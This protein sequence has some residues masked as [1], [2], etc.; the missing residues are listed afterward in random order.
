LTN[1]KENMNTLILQ[2]LMP[3][4]LFCVNLWAPNDQM[5]SSREKELATENL[6]KGLTL[7]T[8][9]F[10]HKSLKKWKAKNLELVDN[11][12]DGKDHIKLT[13]P[14][15]NYDELNEAANALSNAHGF[16]TFE[17]SPYMVVDLYSDAQ[18]EAF[19]SVV[20]NDIRTTLNYNGP[21]VVCSPRL[22]NEN[23][24]VSMDV[25]VNWAGY[26]PASDW[27]D[28]QRQ[29]IV[30]QTIAE[31][32]LNL[33]GRPYSII[34]R[35]TAGVKKF[36]SL[37]DMSL[38]AI[39]IDDIRYVHGQTAYLLK[40]A[41][42]SIL[43]VL[44]ENQLNGQEV[45]PVTWSYEGNSDPTIFLDNHSETSEGVE[46]KAT[47]GNVEVDIKVVLVD[48]QL[49]EVHFGGEG[50]KGLNLIHEKGGLI[51][52]KG[53]DGRYYPKREP[54]GTPI[55][56]EEDEFGPEW[57]KEEDDEISTVAFSAAKSTEIIVKPFLVTTP[58]IKEDLKLLQIKAKINIY[59]QQ[60]EKEQMLLSYDEERGRHYLKESNVKFSVSN[61]IKLVDN[62]T[63]EWFMKEEGGS[64]GTD[65]WDPIATTSH[66]MYQTYK[67]SNYTGGQ[68]Y[69]YY[70]GCGKAEGL[71]INSE[72]AFIDLIWGEFA[73]LKLYKDEFDPAKTR[74]Q[75]PD[76]LR[77]H[78]GFGFLCD[79]ISI[80]SNDEENGIGECG[81]F[82][83]L[84][85]LIL[86]SHG[87]DNVGEHLITTVGREVDQFIVKDWNFIGENHDVLDPRFTHLNIP[88]IKY[89]GRIL[90]VIPQKLVGGNNR[91][92]WVYEEV[93]DQPGIPAQGYDPEDHDNPWSAFGNHK[94]VKIGNAYYDPSYGKIYSSID[95]LND[96][97]SFASQAVDGFFKERPRPIDEAVYNVDLNEDGDM[98][99]NIPWSV[100]LFIKREDSNIKFK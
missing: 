87:I 75:Y 98:N 83:R 32:N 76:P 51:L 43:P 30:E 11:S 20:D 53:K 70:F 54:D 48:L 49:R 33:S 15:A 78:Y 68:E 80:I 9:T 59:G 67:R 18:V 23:G 10:E 90:G 52:V 50:Y 39:E 81:A 19:K 71:T 93:E 22:T 92:N 82:Q 3:A 8:S 96:G 47:H 97:G 58:E 60:L 56:Y 66:K 36:K 63:I 29:S 44:V 61:E 79:N 40:K 55:S 88:K 17:Y 77:Y 91:Y 94:V 73:D 25:Y 69:G 27:T 28:P 62:F 5:R 86:Q 89:T 31:S 16:L 1:E 26:T 84:L 12:L 95:A 2:M 21:Y 100:F 64:G 45:V 42:Q 38:Y 34:D 46:L 37:L 99:D 6:N 65:D 57:S 35:E 41:N 14:G 74:Q 85:I 13:D 72:Q 7:L 4:M 24:I